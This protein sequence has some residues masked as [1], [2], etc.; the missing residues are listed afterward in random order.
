MSKVKEFWGKLK[1]KFKDVAETGSKLLGNTPP[2][3]ILEVVSNML[4]KKQETDPE[5]EKL[6]TELKEKQLEFEQELARMDHEETM[7]LAKIGLEELKLN[8]E[9]KS[10]A[11]NIYSQSKDFADKLAFSIM[12]YNLIGV[13][14]LLLFD[15]LCTFVAEDLKIQY[16]V[17]AGVSTL[18]GMVIQSLLQERQQVTGFYFGSSLGSKSKDEKLK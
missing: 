8:Y 4:G 7:E 15:I 2:G 14:S 10:S 1:T 6:L 5:A 18:I 13:A 9:D 12:R 11:R 16:S 17:V 3:M